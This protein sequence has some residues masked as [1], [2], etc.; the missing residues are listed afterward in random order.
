MTFLCGDLLFTGDT[1]FYEDCG[2][3]DLAGGSYPTIQVSLK[4]LADLPGDYK[5]LPGHGPSSTMEHEREHNPYF[6]W[7]K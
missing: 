4:K 7:K 3:C 5:V 2:R 6:E 1:L